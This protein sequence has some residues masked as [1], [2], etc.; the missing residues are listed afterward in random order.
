[1]A[2]Q[3]STL[4]EFKGLISMLKFFADSGRVNVLDRIG[5]SQSPTAVREAIYEAVRT[6]D[7][8]SRN[9]LRVRI[10]VEAS[11]R[12]EGEKEEAREVTLELECL[13]YE[14]VEDKSSLLGCRGVTG[15]VIESSSPR[16]SP[17]SLICCYTRPLLPSQE[18]L[19]KLFRLLDEDP[20][21]GLNRAKEIASLAFAWKPSR[22]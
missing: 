12:K 21:T 2:S 16:V 3:D 19:D 10:A 4:E 8:L 22:S 17:G 9:P 1:M 6:I 5:F 18:E 11:S 20:M 15:K 7:V 14:V 13:D